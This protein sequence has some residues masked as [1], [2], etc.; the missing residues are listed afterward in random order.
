MGMI[1]L[2]Y[3]VS[4]SG[5]AY[6]RGSDDVLNSLGA[7]LVTGASYRAPG[8]PRSALVGGAVGLV[9]ASAISGTPR[10]RECIHVFFC[11]MSGVKFF[12]LCRCLLVGVQGMMKK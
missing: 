11:F 1:G 2:I 6:L 9:A 12:M 7:G 4:E 3:A 8:G 10:T 5:L